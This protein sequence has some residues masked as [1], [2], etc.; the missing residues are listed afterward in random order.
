[1]IEGVFYIESQ[2]NDEKVVYS[3]L[4][5]LADKMKREKGVTV[6]KTDFGKTKK[7]GDYYSSNLEVDVAFDSLRDYFRTSIRYVP[8]AI[9]LEAPSK[10]KISSED[11]LRILA[12]LTAVSK[13]FLS[14]M[15]ISPS[16]PKRYGKDGEAN[17]YSKGLDSDELDALLDQGAIRVKLVVEMKGEPKEAE[18]RLVSSLGDDVFIHRVKSSKLGSKSLIAV[19]ALM[20]EP[21]TLVELSVKLTPVLIEIVEPEELELSMLEIQDMGLELAAIYFEISHLKYAS[22][23]S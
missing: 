17:D 3:A 15:K 7:E 11:F 14:K 2:G 10:L 18:K 16:M 22:F 8:Y 21:K 19:H 6:K 4:E 23:G 1:M 13:E 12:E 9:V 5:E 20:Y